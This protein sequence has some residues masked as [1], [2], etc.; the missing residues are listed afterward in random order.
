MAKP[1]LILPRRYRFLYQGFDEAVIETSLATKGHSPEQVAARQSFEVRI[2]ALLMPKMSSILVSRTFIEESPATRIFLDEH[3]ALCEQGF[4]KLLTNT[5]DSLREREKKQF[6]YRNVRNVV[7][8]HRAYF[9]SNRPPTDYSSFEIE[10]KDFETG[11]LAHSLWV[12][13]GRGK[14]IHFS[15]ETD[16]DE[17]INR[18]EENDTGNSTWEAVRSSLFSSGVPHEMFDDLHN[19]SFSTYADSH[20]QN[21]VG[22]VI[23]SSIAQSLFTG[24]PMPGDF[25]LGKAR[26]FLLTHDLHGLVPAATAEEIM[27]ARREIQSESA[28]LNANGDRLE[29]SMRLADHIKKV[30]V[31]ARST[32]KPSITPFIE[33]QFKVSLTF[34]G[35]H[36]RYVEQIYSV[37]LEKF[38]VDEVFYDFKFQAELSGPNLDLQLR[39]V[40]RDR[41]DLLVAFLAPSYR[42]SDWCGLEWR[43]VRELVMG[44]SKDD[45]I[46]FVFLEHMEAEEFPDGLSVLD[47]R[48]SVENHTVEEICDMIERRHQLLGP[49]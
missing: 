11:S 2:C 4:L 25:D 8:Y 46:M 30:L 41:S 47:G 39:S 49:L 3:R 37:L 20:R 7:K 17:W 48:I 9:D 27:S 12:D 36:R 40:Y 14:A 34:P 44:R 29:L 28:L 6:N 1:K 15:V 5:S 43:V 16:F 31:G 33:R 10:P 32:R 13:I 19:L 21:G 42:D 45:R 24:S 18:Y 23:G 35:T 26:E 38:S 22:I